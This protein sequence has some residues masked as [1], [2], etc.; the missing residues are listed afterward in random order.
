M[1]RRV[2]EN[3]S[4]VRIAQKQTEPTD[5]EKMDAQSQRMTEREGE[6]KEDSNR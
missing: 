2:N 6:R 4:G 3:T 1:Q 5:D